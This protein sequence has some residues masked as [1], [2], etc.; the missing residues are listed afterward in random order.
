MKIAVIGSGIIGYIASSY[1]SEQGHMVDCI[2][3]RLNSVKSLIKDQH[4]YSS[5][6]ENPVSIKFDREDFKESKSISDSYYQKSAHKFLGLEL[7]DEIGLA[8]YWGANLAIKG[9][10]NELENLNLS[11]D[12]LDFISRSIPVLDVFDFYSDHLGDK[13]N[14][15]MKN[16][17]KNIKYEDSESI[18]SSTLALYADLCKGA[19]LPDERRNSAIFG[20]EFEAPSTYTRID[21]LVEKISFGEREVLPSVLISTPTKK[22][23][24]TY[25][26]ILVTCG[27]IGSYRLINKS[28]RDVDSYPLYSRIK[29]HPVFVTIC[30]VPQIKYPRKYISMSNFDIRMS[31]KYGSVYLN[32]FP[33]KGALKAFN[34]TKYNS[35]I[36]LKLKALLRKVNVFINCLPDIPIFPNWWLHRLYVSNVYLPSEYTSSFIGMKGNQIDLVGGYRFDFEKTAIRRLWPYI[37]FKLVKNKIIPISIWPKIVQI[38]GDLHYSSTLDSFTN[39]EGNIFKDNKPVKRVLVIDS[40][41][42]RILPIANPTYYFV[43]RAIKLLRRFRSEK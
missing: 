4:S 25:D 9:L 33:F 29:H 12:E 22:Y 13:K 35:F 17:L 10:K 30:F 19:D 32:F 39:E 15:N 43:A 28:F 1:L 27:S 23:I 6:Y 34:R 21:G 2:S 36:G 8:R 14:K 40:S 42:S 37:L 16:R 3:P 7:I 24:E 38:G 18:K 26:Y 11:E 41:S 5:S 20:S 31:T